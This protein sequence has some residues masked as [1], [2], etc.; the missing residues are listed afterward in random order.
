[1]DLRNMSAYIFTAK[2][3]TIIAVLL[4]VSMLHPVSATAQNKAGDYYVQ[5]L[6]AKQEGNMKQ[7]FECFSQSAQEGDA[8]AYDC[9]AECYQ[10]GLGVKTDE[11][12]AFEYYEKAAAQGIRHAQQELSTYY[13]QGQRKNQQK[14][15]YWA[16]KAAER[17][18]D[19]TDRDVPQ[20]N[21]S[22]PQFTSGDDELWKYITNYCSVYP[23]EA[24]KDSIQG[25]V[26]VK[27]VVNNH[28]WIEDAKVML[29]PHPSF[30][31]LVIDCVLSMPAWKPARKPIRAG[32]AIDPLS[33]I[34]TTEVVK[35]VIKDLGTVYYKDYHYMLYLS[36]PFRL[37]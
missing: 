26:V 18:Y 19:N 27:F 17:T 13:T 11:S 31:Q 25:K 22:M 36:I 1:M 3:T 9:L 29:S 5:G 15:E 30:N 34:D 12:K 21:G 20:F 4:L 35:V 37:Y 28:G 14:A 24:L 6:H 23:E 8:R 2:A 33:T 7:A 32:D 16:E 10:K